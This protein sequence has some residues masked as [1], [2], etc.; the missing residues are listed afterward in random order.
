MPS[1][2][3]KNSSIDS[4]GKGHKKGGTQQNK[5][6]RLKAID[7]LRRVSPLDDDQSGQWEAFRSAWDDIL[8]VRHKDKWAEV[9][10]QMLQD[11]LDKLING[12]ANALSSFMEIEKHRVLK[13]TAFFGVPRLLDQA[14]CT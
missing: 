2:R 6:N 4:F 12:E 8:A 11:V 13:D 5:K 7:R 1:L 9:F 14:K 3:T 10:T